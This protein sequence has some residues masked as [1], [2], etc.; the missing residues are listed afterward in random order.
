MLQIIGWLLCVY[1]VVKGFELIAMK[2]VWSYVGAAIA[3]IAAPI[4]LLLINA[5][6]NATP[7]PLS[8]SYSPSSL[9]DVNTE[10]QDINR[11]QTS[12]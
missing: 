1:L 9:S 10:A 7:S 6:S 12:R 5:Q 2:S 3:F 11:P 8:Q 4:F